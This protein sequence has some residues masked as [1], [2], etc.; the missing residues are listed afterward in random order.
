MLHNVLQTCLAVSTSCMLQIFN[1]SERSVILTTF[2]NKYG[3]SRHV[4]V[5]IFILCFPFYLSLRFSL[6]LDEVFRFT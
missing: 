4:S 6:V 5:I 2:M 1:H 3:L